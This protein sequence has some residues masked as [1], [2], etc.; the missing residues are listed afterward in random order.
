[1][2]KIKS[3]ELLATGWLIILELEYKQLMKVF[4]NH[5]VAA[6]I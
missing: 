4:H 6:N 3:I 1:M 2:L 5:K